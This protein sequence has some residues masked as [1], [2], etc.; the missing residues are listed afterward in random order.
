MITYAVRSLK[1]VCIPVVVAAGLLLTCPKA[2]LAQEAAEPPEFKIEIEERRG[3]GL[4]ILG[5]YLGYARAEGGPLL[6]NPQ[7]G[8]AFNLHAT[9]RHRMGESD[10]Y[11][12]F[13]PE[14][15]VSDWSSLQGM[16][17]SDATLYQLLVSGVLEFDNRESDLAP[18]VLLGGGVVEYN[19]DTLGGDR[20][21]G[22]GALQLGIGARYYMEDRF[23]LNL[24]S[25]LTY[26]K[27]FTSTGANNIRFSLG[28]G[29]HFR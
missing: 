15:A 24:G 3:P 1:L 17:V 4:L 7:S 13:R 26:L 16:P 14:F 20:S 22:G 12:G 2:S 9:Y 11:L 25:E 8:V 29:F 21:L 10:L 23:G 6:R 28:L 19:L 27:D 18:Y 5:W